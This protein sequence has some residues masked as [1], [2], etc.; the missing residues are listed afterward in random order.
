MKWS[1][2]FL[3]FGVILVF[4]PILSL[5]S[6]SNDSYEIEVKAPEHSLLFVSEEI[7]LSNG[8][9]IQEKRGIATDSLKEIDFHITR[10]ALDY[11]VISADKVNRSALNQHNNI[12]ISA[13]DISEGGK[14]KDIFSEAIQADATIHLYGEVTPRVFAEYLGQEYLYVNTYPIDVETNRENIDLP[15]KH[16][17]TQELDAEYALKGEEFIVEEDKEFNV[18]SVEFENGEPVSILFSES[19]KN[20][21]A[22]EEYLETILFSLSTDIEKEGDVSFNDYNDTTSWISNSKVT[23]DHSRTPIDSRYSLTRSIYCDREGILSGRTITDWWLFSIDNNDAN[24]DYFNLESATQYREFNGARLV[25]TESWYRMV[26]DNDELRDS[27]PASTNWGSN[28]FS[29]SIP[30]GFNYNWDTNNSASVSHIQDRA[31][32]YAV[33]TV[34]GLRN[35][36]EFKPGLAAA[37]IESRRYVAINYQVHSTWEIPWGPLGG[38]YQKTD[39]PGSMWARYSY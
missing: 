38:V 17:F 28:S 19:N 24:Y 22:T 4:L 8:G 14:A 35:Y 26:Y 20:N 27:D 6:N 10:G 1:W 31:A 21:L 33:W 2:C 32:D 15:I 34:S 5:S 13:K 23:G 16:Y 39:R 9:D 18:I 3:C 29:V 11:N 12:A 30:W 36:D 37:T 25:R 7:E